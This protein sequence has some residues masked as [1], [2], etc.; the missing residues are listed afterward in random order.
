MKTANEILAELH[1]IRR[2]GY[3]KTLPGPHDENFISLARLYASAT[4]EERAGI[5]SAVHDESRMLILGF[6]D[7]LA[8]LAARAADAELLFLALIA[9]SLEDFRIDPRENI[10]RLALVNHVC[11]KIGQSPS[12]MIERVA[13]LSSP[14]AAQHLRAFVTVPAVMKSLRAMR[15]REVDTPEGVDYKNF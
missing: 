10:F 1:A 11:G 2:R 3:G 14:D 7:R 4:D 12:A 5:R 8:T 15:I 13:R 9:H 6:S